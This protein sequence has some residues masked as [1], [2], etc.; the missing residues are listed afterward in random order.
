MNPN[1]DIE[2]KAVCEI[3]K[4]SDDVVFTGWKY[5]FLIWRCKKCRIKFET[6]VKDR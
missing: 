6:P 3:C 1:Q 5:N 4:S 2:Q